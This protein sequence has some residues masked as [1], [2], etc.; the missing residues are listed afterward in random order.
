MYVIYI[1]HGCW[2]KFGAIG[3]NTS[4]GGLYQI[5]ELTADPGRL[6]RAVGICH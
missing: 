1:L 2:V 5:L 4:T 6:N 3:Q